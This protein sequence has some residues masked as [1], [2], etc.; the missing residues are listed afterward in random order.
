VA[1]T[2]APWHCVREPVRKCAVSPPFNGI[3]RT[4]MSTD[5]P[6]VE[7]VWFAVAPDGTEHTLTLRIGAPYLRPGGEWAADASLGV[8]DTHT[9]SIVGIDSWQAVH[10][11]MRF[12]A[13]GVRHYHAVGWR[14][15]WERGGEEAPPTDLLG[16]Q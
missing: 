14:Y 5:A 15:F 11:S 7:R 16:G 10:E 1:A 13:S 8:L 6:Y 9:H 12:I 2:C 3:V 4:L